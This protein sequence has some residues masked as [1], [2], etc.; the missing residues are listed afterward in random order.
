MSPPLALVVPVH[1]RPELVES[2]FR[3]LDAWERELDLVAVDDGSTAPGIEALRASPPGRHPVRWLR[4]ERA[5]G[6]SAAVN[7][8]V[9][10]TAGD[11]ILLLNSDAEVGSGGDEALL[12]ALARHPEAGAI[13]ARLVYPDGT[14]QWSGGAE[15]TPLW[16][17]ALASG[18]GERRGRARAA[19]NRPPSGHVGGEV[20]WAPAAALAIR[21]SAWLATGPLDDGFAHYAQDLDYGHRLRQRGYRI[22]VEPE[23]VVAHHLGGSAGAAA[24]AGQRLDRLWLD[25]LRWVGKARGARAARR[26]RGVLRAGARFRL[27]RL[28][29]AG[30]PHRAVEAARVREALSALD[31]AR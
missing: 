27:A 19:R 31:G 28:A 4:N 9:A 25:L 20:E 14:P 23:F 5:L 3:S 30:G 10:A 13:A 6:F 24:L 21:R 7:R 12:G 15:P 26:A 22:R 11:P 29:L 2:C 1:D 18:L 17:F 16:L 8:G